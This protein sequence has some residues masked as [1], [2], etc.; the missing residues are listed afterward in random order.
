MSSDAD[1]NGDVGVDRKEVDGMDEFACPLCESV[2][3]EADV[4]QHFEAFHP[5]YLADDAPILIF[6]QRGT[7]ARY[8]DVCAECRVRTSALWEYVSYN[9]G[10]VTIC[11]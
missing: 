5:E 1:P 11:G 7:R 10:Y 4:D 9:Y 2:V 6:Q 3:L 8:E